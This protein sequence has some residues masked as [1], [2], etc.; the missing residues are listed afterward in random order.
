MAAA[1]VTQ[2]QSGRS[3]FL[4]ARRRRRQWRRRRTGKSRTSPR[5]WIDSLTKR[6]VRLNPY[7]SLR[8]LI[9]AMRTPSSTIRATSHNASVTLK[10]R[11]SVVA[12]IPGSWSASTA[13]LCRKAR[14][15]FPRAAG[16]SSFHRGLQ[17]GYLPAHHPSSIGSGAPHHSSQ[18][19]NVS[20]ERVYTIKSCL[21]LEHDYAGT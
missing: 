3:S 16:L 6:G 21:F 19:G 12:D 14:D 13:S 2:R 20:V 10:V 8:K 5:W 18:A 1:V 11:S 4:S 7:H 15:K 9:S 17:I